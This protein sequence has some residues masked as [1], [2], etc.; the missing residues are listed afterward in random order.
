VKALKLFAITAITTGDH[1]DK[2]NF[3]KEYNYENGY[4]A[5]R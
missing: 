2:G 4:N 3:N 1:P 5:K